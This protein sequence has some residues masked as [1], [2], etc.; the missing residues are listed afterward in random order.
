[1]KIERQKQRKS[2]IPVLPMVN[3]VFLLLVFFLV[4]GTIEQI[5]IVPIDP[6]MAE[7]GKILDEGH[8]VI[9]LGRYDEIV[10]DDQLVQKEEIAPII[11]KKLEG[12]PGKVITIKA[13]SSL[14]SNSLIAIMDEVKA[15]G[16]HNVSLMTQ[17]PI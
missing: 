12:Y 6:P 4:S 11:R 5:E 7:S 13:D 9:L 8:V 14:K 10:I 17:S 2:E 3:V 15:A 16:G 1:M